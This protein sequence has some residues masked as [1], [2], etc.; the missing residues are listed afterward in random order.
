MRTA[1]FQKALAQLIF[2]GFN[3]R[4]VALDR[5]TGETI[6]QW[7]SPTGTGY[8]TV[9]LDGDRLIV[10]VVGYTYC[11]DPLTGNQLWFNSLAG[12]GVGVASLASVNGVATG[13][14]GAANANA[15][16]AAAS[17]AH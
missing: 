2:A 10:S 8:V 7:K 9:L 11:L 6:W 13:L 17:A 1:S 5:E 15:Q 3:S 14:L 12:C 4:V 16:A